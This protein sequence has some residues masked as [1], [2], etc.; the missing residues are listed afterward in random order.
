MLTVNDDLTVLQAVAQFISYA[1][2]AIF[3]ENVIFSRALGVSRV[4]KLVGDPDVKTWQYCTPVILV[5]VF[6]APG[7]WFI[8]NLFF[9]Y[10]RTVL[11]DWLPLSALRPLFYLLAATLAMAVVWLLLGLTPAPSRAAFREQLPLAAFNCSVLG[12]LLIAA[13]QNYTLLQFIAFGL[14]SGLGYLFAV[15]IM[16]EGRRRL[17]SKAIP[18]V[19]RGLPS[20]LIYIGILSLALYGLLGHGIA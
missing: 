17:R 15:L 9:P 5:Q 2:L 10:L 20:Y 19:F 1:L 12:T 8:H 3:T 4:I 13:N 11:P 16:D 18:A 7:G 14:G 6:S